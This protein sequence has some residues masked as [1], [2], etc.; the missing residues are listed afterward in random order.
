MSPSPIIL[1]LTN[2]GDAQHRAQQYF[3]GIWRGVTALIL[4]SIAQL[5]SAGPDRLSGEWGGARTR[6]ESRGIVP[7]AD[8]V[9][10][11]WSNLHGG[12][13]TG[14]RYEGFGRWGAD[15]DLEKLT[16]WRGTS[17][18]V[19]WFSYHGGQPSSDLVGQFGTNSVTEW[20]ADDSIRFYNIYLQREFLDGALLLRAGQLAAD[21]E[22]FVAEYADTLLNGAF[23]DFS[24]GRAQQL[25]PFYP[26]AGPGIYGLGRT[27]RWSLRFGAYTADPGKEE[28]SNV[29]LDWNLDAGISFYT[30]LDLHWNPA[31]LPGTYSIGVGATTARLRNFDGERVDDNW[32]LHVVFNQTLALDAQNEPA[33]GVFLG[34]GLSPPDDRS[35]ARSYLNAGVSIFGPI[36][37]RADD[38][39]TVGVAYT[40]L[41]NDYIA[42]LRATGQ[43]VSGHET[44]IE[45]AYRAAITPWLSLQPDLQLFVDPHFSRRDA[46]VLGLQ[47][48]FTF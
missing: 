33:L 37:G 34:A 4:T 2:T 8:Y 13:D 31:S 16:R 25:A 30:Q 38:V 22:F 17:F 43:K 42:S 32:S 28:S 1:G 14:T 36:P 11:F 5:A 40:D 35:I 10:G 45:L 48:R 20:E 24:S 27:D 9:S 41:S 23:G 46:L 6:L 29:G 7:F 39:L 12:A 44:V 47:A 21:D 3:T 26:L 18:H 19:D 15:L